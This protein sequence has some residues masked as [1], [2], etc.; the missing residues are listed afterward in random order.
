MECISYWVTFGLTR[1]RSR[2]DKDA[3]NFHLTLIQWGEMHG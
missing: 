2:G 1:A 3:V